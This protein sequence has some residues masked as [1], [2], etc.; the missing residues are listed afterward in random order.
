MFN[1]FGAL[2]IPAILG[3]GLIEQ[4]LHL[5]GFAFV[6]CIFLPRAR[7]VFDLA[8][9]ARAALFPASN[10]TPSPTADEIAAAVAKALN[11]IPVK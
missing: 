3:G 10:V 2:Q 1:L 5:C 4:G 11:P 6:A 8:D 7:V 9:K